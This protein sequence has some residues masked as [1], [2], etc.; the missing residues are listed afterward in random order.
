M[1]KDKINMLLKILKIISRNLDDKHL[2]NVY[3]FNNKLINKFIINYKEMYPNIY[4]QIISTLKIKTLNLQDLSYEI[5]LRIVFIQFS[6][7]I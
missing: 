3:S 6:N 5:K 1:P 7:L 2:I 4:K